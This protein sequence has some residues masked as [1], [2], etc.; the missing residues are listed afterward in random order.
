[1]EISTNMR[2]T[3]NPWK[4]PSSSG[5]ADGDA[6]ADGARGCGS[7][8]G[9]D[10]SRRCGPSRFCGSSCG[11]C[12]SGDGRGLRCVP[13]SRFLS[14]PRSRIDTRP[15][16][17]RSPRTTSREQSTQH[18]WGQRYQQVQSARDSV[19]RL[20][21]AA[22]VSARTWPRNLNDPHS[23]SRQPLGPIVNCFLFTFCV[24]FPCPKVEGC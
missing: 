18:A 16:S 20:G 23:T 13:R 8:R 6:V 3:R 19:T 14:Q 2:G 7:S 22:P 1:M 21:I 15:Q 5:F 10:P 12:R 4:M 11:H 9:H 24:L 17:Q